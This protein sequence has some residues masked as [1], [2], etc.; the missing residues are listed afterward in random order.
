MGGG[1]LVWYNDSMNS[2]AAITE[3]DILAEVVAPDKAGLSPEA[4]RAILGLK[5]GKEATKEMRRLLQ[6]NNRGTITAVE[7]VALER[8]LRVGRFLDLLRAKARL[9]LQDSSDAR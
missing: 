9:S 6:K 1:L 5:F 2:T 3:A 8:Y 4:A 7:R